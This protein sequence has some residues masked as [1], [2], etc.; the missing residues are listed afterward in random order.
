MDQKAPAS[1]G[2]DTIADDLATLFQF[3]NIAG[4]TGAG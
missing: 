4:E 3:L 2:G 1:T